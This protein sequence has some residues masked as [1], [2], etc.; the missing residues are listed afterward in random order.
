MF[1]NWIG[2]GELRRITGHEP[3]QPVVSLTQIKKDHAV[4]SWLFNKYYNICFVDKN[5]E[6][7]ADSPPLEDEN[8]WEHRVIKQIV[9]W[10][11]K[12]FAVGTHLYGNV[13]QQSIEPYMINDALHSMIRDSPHNARR[14]L[15]QTDRDSDADRA[16]LDSGDNDGGDDGAVF[17]SSDHDDS[18]NGDT[19]K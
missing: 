18:D 3:G 13:D 2:P 6:G 17:D 11:R 8:E 12:G 10:K 5:P 15:S 9:W 7:H 19:D 16:V 14:L 4:K 1:Q